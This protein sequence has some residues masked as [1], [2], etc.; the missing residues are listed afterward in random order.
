MHQSA[1]LSRCLLNDVQDARTTLF[2]STLRMH[3]LTFRIYI[4]VFCTFTTHE[5][6]VIQY[7]ISIFVRIKASLATGNQTRLVPAR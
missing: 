6:I 4:H 1:D 3:T 2:Y 5:R 7:I